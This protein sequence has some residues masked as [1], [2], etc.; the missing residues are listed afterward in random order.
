[1]STALLPVYSKQDNKSVSE[2]NLLLLQVLCYNKTSYFILDRCEL[3]RIEQITI[4]RYSNAMQPL[5]FFFAITLL[6][7][8]SQGLLAQA[9][10]TDSVAAK[11]AKKFPISG[12]AS[13]S[14][15]TMIAESREYVCKQ[16]NILSDLKWPLTPS[17][18]YTLHCGLYFPKGVHLDGSVSFMQPLQTNPM[19]DRDF[20]GI[21]S[22]PM[23][24]GITKSSE[25]KCKI[26][27]GLRWTVKLGLQLPMPQTTMMRKKQISIAVEPLIS[28]YSSAISWHAYD[29]YLQYAEMRTD[30]SYKT[31]TDDLPKVPFTGPAVSYRQQLMIPAI[32]IGFEAAFPYKLSLS[33]D[34]HVSSAIIALAEDIHHVRNERFVDLIG[35]GWGVHGTTRLSWQ[36]RPYF[37]LFCSIFYEYSI[38][39]EGRTLSYS[40]ISS[41]TPAALSPFN[42]AGTSLYGCTLSTG[43]AFVVG[44]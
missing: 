26:L 34:F 2:K 21:L 11:K 32:G 20:E 13:F 15:N 1:M 12:F 38:S 10:F 40:G 27:N 18:S 44:R 14:I 37:A 16:G 30:G 6:F 25:H 8:S 4:S 23:Q 36:C 31:W 24:T 41:K 5:R 22:E 29:G 43:V 3:F 33:S 7:I 42:S 17:L 9:D 28:I 19:I 35:G 39:L